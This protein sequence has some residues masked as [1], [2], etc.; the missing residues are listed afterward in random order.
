M[1]FNTILAELKL[2]IWLQPKVFLQQQEAFLASCK[3]IHPESGLGIRRLQ[4][5][6]APGGPLYLYTSIRRQKDSESI[7][8]DDC[9]SLQAGWV[10]DISVKSQPYL[11][12]RYVISNIRP[13]YKV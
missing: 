4:K 10:T 2:N 13:E 6:V 9:E 8:E 7:S 12:T 3:G 11:P 5:S 1:S